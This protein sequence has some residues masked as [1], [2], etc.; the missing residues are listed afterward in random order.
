LIR[1]AALMG[2]SKN[3]NNLE[4]DENMSDSLQKNI[5]EK[6]RK[7]EYNLLV[8]TSVAAEGV[9]I[10]GYIRYFLGFEEN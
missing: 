2:K 4:T 1:S 10:P 3:I 6:F 5:L 7:L 8:V 9:D